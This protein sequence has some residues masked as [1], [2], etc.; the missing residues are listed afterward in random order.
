MLV[1]EKDEIAVLE[2]NLTN[3]EVDNVP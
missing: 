3:F 2:A 1:G